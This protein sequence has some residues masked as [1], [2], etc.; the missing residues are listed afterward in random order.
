MRK[1]I[2]FSSTFRFLVPLCAL[3]FWAPSAMAFPELNDAFRAKYVKPDSTEAND[4]AFSQAYSQATCNVCHIGSN[5]RMR[6]AYGKELAKLVTRRDARNKN[7]IETALERAAQLKSDPADPQAPTF[8]QRITDGKL[9]V[10]VTDTGP[11]DGSGPPRQAG[12]RGPRGRRL[13][14]GKGPNEPGDQQV[15]PGPGGPPGGPD[16]SGPG[17]PPDRQPDGP[18]DRPGLQGPGQPPDGP[19]PQLGPGRSSA[20][21]PEIGRLIEV[22]NDLDR[23][24][25]GLAKTYRDAP[26]DQRAKLKEDLKKLVTEQFETWQQRRKLEIARLEEEL[27]RIRTATESRVKDKPQMIDKR[28]NDLLGE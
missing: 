6:N 4:V 28:V 26:Q 20:V 12:P 9:P 19:P 5:K 1:M 27:N 7:R 2:G 3:S 22:S 17:Q 13:P 18:P 10:T 15:G 24:A 8:G 16:S 21:D 11:A 14:P 25:H 23:R